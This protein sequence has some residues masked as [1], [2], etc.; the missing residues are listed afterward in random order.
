[1]KRPLFPHLAGNPLFSDLPAELLAQLEAGLEPVSLET[2]DVLVRQGDP[3]DALF[4]LIEGTLEVQVHTPS[5]GTVTVDSLLPG[6]SV[7][8]MAL[9][10]GQERT[11]TVVASSPATLVRL[12]SVDFERLAASSKELRQAVIRQMQPRLQRIQLGSVL[13]K[14]FPELEAAQIRELQDAVSWTGLQAG[15]QL[16]LQGDEADG[17]YLL[18]SG[19]LRRSALGADGEERQLGEVAR[20]SSIGELAVLG[21][22]VRDETVTAI[23]DSQVVRLD[24]N[25]LHEH[26]QVLVQIA[27]NALAR[28]VAS[29][30]GQ[31][32]ARGSGVRTLLLLPAR[33]G[34]PA[35]ALAE[36][37][38]QQLPGSLVLDSQLVDR[39][40]GQQGAANTR[41]DEDL[42]PALT[43]W[44]NE[45]EARHEQLLLVA[46]ANLSGWTRRCLG[47]ADRIL[48][49]ADADAA[50]ER[51]E[52]ERALATGVNAEVQLVLVQKDETLLPQGTARWLAER[53]PLTHHHVRL[54]NA[55][56]LGRLARRL[57]GRA[58]G[59]VLS[60]GGARAY[61]HLGLLKVIE[62]LGV[63]VDM[64][65]GTSM[66]ALIGGVYAHKPAFEHCYRTASRFGDPRMLLDKT[67]PLVALAE[68]RNVTE[69]FQSMFGEARIEDLWLPYVCVSANLTRAEPVLHSQ[70]RLWEAVRA[71]TAIPGVFTPVVSDG[72]ILVDGGIMNNYPVDIMREQI[73]SGLVIGSN[74]ES[75]ARNR[76][77]EFGHSISGWRV[78]LER[79][80][81]GGRRKRYPSIIGTLMR[82]TSVSSKHLGA[83]A[84]SLADV[85]VR[86]P[87]QD[88]GNLEFDRFAELTD[89]G[90]SA[91]LEVLAPWWE[92]VSGSSPGS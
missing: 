50:P 29:T 36:G 91:G 56:D 23:R 69:V 38:Q 61:V 13:E 73:G 20:G 19:R 79:L 4:V 43:H 1:M 81:P 75:A 31:D 71:S 10:A 90:Y 64:V 15:Q 37:L 70:G 9:V 76:A 3:G 86:Y 65:A 57:T 74:A 27:R 47:M 16:Y 39:R 53:P 21:G 18:V 14:W 62:E 44:L 5:G 12:R 67:L 59:L 24:S 83:S 46:D 52:A 88:F 89:I 32:G 72:D 55:A 77:F 33:T 17:M 45:M 60:G 87:A 66:G 80:R 78:L 92:R 84:D 82:A 2:G 58:V 51:G 85:V 6:A 25:H 48:V 22:G 26:P 8:E 42:D 63:P 7:G 30:R 35:A 34:A 54:G 28:V 49:V 68:S 11:A 40:F 41:R